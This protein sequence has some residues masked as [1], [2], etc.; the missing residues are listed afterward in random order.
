MKNFLFR[1]PSEFIM[2][3]GINAPNLTMA[4]KLIKKRY[5]FKIIPSDLV[6]WETDEESFNIE[7]SGL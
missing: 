7:R 6:V 2:M 1:I 3:S 4:K 5:N